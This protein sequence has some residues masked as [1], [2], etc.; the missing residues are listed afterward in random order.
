LSENINVAL[1]RLFVNRDDDFAIQKPD[2]GYLRVGQPLT[3]EIIQQH[4][5]GKM[6]I[7]PYQLNQFNSVKNICFD[8][9]PEKLEDPFAT[10]KTILETL[11]EED[12]DKRPRIWRKAILLEAS[13][14]PDNSAHLWIFFEP[15][16]PA[17]VAKW[18]GYRIIE[19]ANL[20][21]KQIEVFPK[22]TKLTEDRP[23]G[24]LVKLPLGLHQVERKYSRFLNLDT[25]KPQ[26]PTCLFATE[27]ISFSEADLQKIMSFQEKQNV[28][29]TFNPPKTFKTLKRGKEARITKFL[30]S[31]WKEGQ[32]N[33]VEMAFL[34]WCIK[35]GIS[36]YSATRIID[37]VTRLTN[38][39]ERYSRLKLVKY[40]YQNRLNIGPKLLGISGLKQIVE[41][42]IQ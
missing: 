22:Q 36:P 6:T 9:D 40:H 8:L 1:Q 37:Q 16:V 5:K 25:F 10:A 3:T 2:T 42:T 29:S 32:R 21:P 15:L 14:Y 18:L 17:K 28:Q 35:R 38:D 26:S 34:G 20:N 4:V 27:G 33:R 7:G 11:L 39:P 24:N 12:Q 30:C 23:F 13:R 31:Y 41:E 19:L